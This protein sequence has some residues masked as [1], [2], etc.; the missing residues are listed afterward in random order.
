MNKRPRRD[1][2]LQRVKE[3]I[4]LDTALFQ[5]RPFHSK[6]P[7]K[8]RTLANLAVASGLPVIPRTFLQETTVFL[9][10]GQR[11]PEL[12]SPWLRFE[13]NDAIVMP[14]QPASDIEPQPDTLSLRLGRKERIKDSLANMCGDPGTIV[15]DA[16]YNTLAF[17]PD[18]HF[19]AA[20]LRRSVERIL[21]QVSPYLVQF[22]CAA[23]NFG[24]A[25]LEIYRNGHALF[26]RL[27]SQQLHRVVHS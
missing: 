22:A 25:S 5:I 13:F 4:P 2:L 9:A 27:R 10:D 23:A 11:N 19:N 6:S 17:S 12:G 1:P 21:D 20:I 7:S 18:H 26:T 15:D 3:P 14:N 8:L 16:H 24:Q